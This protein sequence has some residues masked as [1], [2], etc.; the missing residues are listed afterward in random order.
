M[1]NENGRIKRD[2]K[3]VKDRDFMITMRI[4]FWVF[5]EHKQREKL[6]LFFLSLSL[7]FAVE[8]KNILRPKKN[9]DIWLRN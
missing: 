1:N 9:C 3:L 2:F 5:T 6:F 8:V 7:S 4:R